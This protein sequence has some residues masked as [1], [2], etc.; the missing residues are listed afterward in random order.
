MS[1][2]ADFA[3]IP[4][5]GH[6][7]SIC[8]PSARRL[9]GAPPAATR[10][11]LVD[12]PILDPNMARDVGTGPAK[13][14]WSPDGRWL[15]LVGCACRHRCRPQTSSVHG[16]SI[17]DPVFS[18]TDGASREFPIPTRPRQSTSPGPPTAA[19]SSSTRPTPC[20]WA[21]TW[22][23]T[24][25]S[26]CCGCPSTGRS[27]PSDGHIL[28]EISRVGIRSCGRLRYRPGVRRT[29]RSDPRSWTGSRVHGSRPRSS[30]GGGR[31]F[32]PREGEVR[33]ARGDR[34]RTPGSQRIVAARL[35]A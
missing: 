10:G 23:W 31:S 3:E 15:A 13:L 32:G 14:A 17:R 2:T 4:Y 25:S 16:P 24:R 27:C 34:L 11:S 22:S 29:G 9:A 30:P 26:N 1:R 35:V 18:T 28:A 12:L 19:R 21:W 20:P 7:W 8:D 33:G 6:H 5:R